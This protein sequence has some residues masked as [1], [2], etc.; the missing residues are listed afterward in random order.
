[1]NPFPPVV[2][3]EGY[4]CLAAQAYVSSYP[5]TALALVSPPS[6]IT[7]VP[8]HVLPTDVDEFDFEPRFPI[9]IFSPTCQAQVLRQKNRLARS[10]FV[11]LLP[12]NEDLSSS[13][14][15]WL[16]TLYV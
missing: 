3:A 9:A 8:R 13:I 11:D 14:G 2:I 10:E 7:D 15:H 1:M 5:A 6:T 12:Y 16:D 4:G